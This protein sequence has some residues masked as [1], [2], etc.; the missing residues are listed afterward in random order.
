LNTKLEN[1]ANTRRDK[2]PIRLTMY[3]GMELVI[4]KELKYVGLKMCNFFHK[5]F[6]GLE[7][8]P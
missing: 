8:I 5:C 4:R 7:E 2:R 1:N 3:Y 6:M